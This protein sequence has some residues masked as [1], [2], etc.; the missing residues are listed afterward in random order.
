MQRSNAQPA[1]KGKQMSV[2]EMHQFISRQGGGREFGEAPLPSEFQNNLINIGGR[3]GQPTRMTSLPPELASY[4]RPFI[5]KQ[6]QG[7]EGG[8]AAQEEQQGEG[9]SSGQMQQQNQQISAQAIQQQRIQ[10]MMMQRQAAGGRPIM[11][12][13]QVATSP[14]QPSI[15]KPSFLGQKM[16]ANIIE[17]LNNDAVMRQNGLDTEGRGEAELED[18]LQQHGR[19]MQPQP[20]AKTVVKNGLPRAPP[21][22]ALQTP[23][24]KPNN[25][26]TNTIGT[27]TPE[28]INQFI[29]QQQ[30]AA[31]QQEQQQDGGNAAK[32]NGTQG[33]QQQQPNL[34]DLQYAQQQELLQMM[35]QQPNF[36]PQPLEEDKPD[37]FTQEQ[38]RLEQS[39]QRAA[40]RLRQGQ[41][42]QQTNG[43]G[44]G[45]NTPQ[46]KT[47]VVTKPKPQRVEQQQQQQQEQ[48]ES[49]QP[50]WV[51]AETTPAPALPTYTPEQQALFLQQHQEFLQ[52]QYA[53]WMMQQQQQM[54]P[55][56]Q[57][58]QQGVKQQKPFIQ[59]VS[60]S[61]PSV[62]SRPSMQRPNAAA[63]AA[64]K[65][66]IAQEQTPN[67]VQE[68][69]IEKEEQGGEDE[70][71]EKGEEV[72]GSANATETNQFMSAQ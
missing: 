49:N 31:R 42:Q 11:P 64:V 44:N 37:L 45:N 35:Q 10:Q 15:A 54:Q 30:L 14:L 47:L 69:G 9:A 59:P 25:V 39:V 55:M 34:W 66:E 56:M 13:Q 40:P 43:S 41:Q 17:T 21:Q 68:G 7:G 38:Q 20:K 70:Q 12:Q 19:P 26:A 29:A 71:E 50:A 53:I 3:Y 65:Q 72:D 61:V 57:G 48:S 36:V 16:T 46:L 1:Q 4:A 67:I 27:L 28:Q 23:R 60:S 24:P 62:F 58:A 51:P 63:P 6:Q 2:Q 22:I 32:T 8:E 52:Q 18:I 33:Q 5:S